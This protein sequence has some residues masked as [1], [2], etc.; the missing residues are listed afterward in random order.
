M[1][2]PAHTSLAAI[3][4]AGREIVEADGLAGLTMQR[5]ASAVGVRPPSLY[6]RVRNRGDLVRLI[7]SEVARELGATLE[8]TATTGEPRADLRAIAVGFRAFAHA[9]PQAHRLLFDPLPDDL[10]PDPEASREAVEVLFR[11]LSALV[12]PADVLD[13]ARTLVAWAYGFV[14]MELADTFRLGGDVDRAFAFAVE[15]LVEA[16]A[17]VAGMPRPAAEGRATAANQ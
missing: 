16:I 11:V 12:E 4:Q 2:T 14:S 10:R 9:H 7:G 3:V 15:R 1:P 5:V 17:P 8:Q 13:A 6:K